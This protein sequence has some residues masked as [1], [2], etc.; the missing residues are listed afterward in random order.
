MS[1]QVNRGTGSCDQRI[2]WA[3]AGLGMWEL[4]PS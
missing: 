2:K 1:G 3:A 4:A